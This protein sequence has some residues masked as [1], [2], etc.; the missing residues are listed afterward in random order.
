MVCENDPFNSRQKYKWCSHVGGN[1]YSMRRPHSVVE[2][3]LPIRYPVLY[4]S[5]LPPLSQLRTYAPS[6]L[7][8]LNVKG[9]SCT[10]INYERT[11]MSG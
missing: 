9:L 5:L 7:V 8:T 2:V 4:G 11:R 6:K 1:G 10:G 3:V